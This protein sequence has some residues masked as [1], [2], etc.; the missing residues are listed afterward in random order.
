MNSQVGSVLFSVPGFTSTATGG[1]LL[2]C[3]DIDNL[4][5]SSSI[6]KIIAHS[7]ILNFSGD[8][9]KREISVPSPINKLL[10]AVLL[11][12]DSVYFSIIR[13]IWSCR[14]FN[15]CYF[16][17]GTRSWIYPFFA[18]LLGY[19][20]LIRAHNVEASY[21]RS[22]YIESHGDNDQGLGK[23]FRNYFKLAAVS[24]SEYISSVLADA[25]FTLTEDDRRYFSGRCRDTIKLPY[26]PLVLPEIV[27]AMDH[28][29][30]RVIFVG[31]LD[32]YPNREAHDLILSIAAST[33]GNIEFHFFGRDENVEK[34][35][36]ENIIYHGFVDELSTAYSLGDVFLCPIQTGAGM[37]LKVAEALSYGVPVLVSQHSAKGYEG[38]PG[39]ELLPCQKSGSKK[40][41]YRILDRY[42][43]KK[44]LQKHYASWQ[45][46]LEVNKKFSNAINK[47]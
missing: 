7:N 25:I 20:I 17:E 6:L 43:S 36:M 41:I 24:F 13:E 42:P 19:R 44:D 35:K 10:A 28:E 4:R 46:S 33:G 12:G 30:V 45:K 34:S 32:F 18:K 15:S 9:G 29:K 5:A 1:F 31:S 16:Q 22:V 37:K 27:E 26:F 8:L 40:S 21:F 2:N 3:H 11:N 14:N 38:T 47:C 23:K 39:V